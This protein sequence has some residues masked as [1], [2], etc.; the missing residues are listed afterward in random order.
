[1]FFL[2]RP[3]SSRTRFGFGMALA[4]E[5]NFAMPLLVAAPLLAAEGW[6][7]EHGPQQSSTSKCQD[8]TLHQVMS[9]LPLQGQSIDQRP[10]Q[11][12]PQFREKQEPCSRLK[13]RRAC[14]PTA[15]FCIEAP[16]FCRPIFTSE[17]RVSS[18]TCRGPAVP[19]T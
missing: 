3:P 18:P 1:M 16:S 7:W 5:V 13:L 4:T 11:R 8:N 15:H 14:R 6:G 19:V 9:S 10:A 12:E 2:C 17:I